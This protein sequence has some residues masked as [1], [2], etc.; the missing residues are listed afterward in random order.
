M[1]TEVR[2]RRGTTAQHVG[3][4]GAQAELTID[5][6]KKTAVVHDGVTPGGFP[7]AVATELVGKANSGANSD[8][9]SL[10]G[11]TTP[12]SI[13]QG[14]TGSV[15]AATARTALGAAASGTLASSGITGAAASGT[16]SDITSLT[17]LTT[18]ISLVPTATS[19]RNWRADS[20]GV[21]NYNV[22]C[23]ADEVVLR[24]STGNYVVQASVSKTINANGVVGAPLSIMSARAASTWYYIWLWYN[25]SL[26]LTATL[27]IS[28]TVPTAPTG[29]VAGDYK[30]LMPGARRTDAS[31]NTY[32]LGMITRGRRTRYVVL[33]G[34]NV[35]G[36]LTMASGT[37]GST[38]TPTWVAIATGT[39]VPVTAISIHGSMQNSGGPSGLIMVAPN[40]SYG[41]INSN[42][43][44]PY[45]FVNSAT[46]FG[47]RNFE[48][49][50]ES[51]NIYWAA[52]SGSFIYCQGWE[53]NL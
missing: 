53:E 39:F 27:D 7:L 16:N 11:L 9:T 51:T 5:T 23:S 20:T 36:T 35:T 4:T 1:A 42:T 31:G 43:N 26:G 15:S 47:Q 33:T 18:P 25:A 21:S 8:I 44:S 48:L 19:F 40:N 2:L 32:L 24:N 29:Y 41:A 28:S 52:N 38:A 3:F 45:A 13:P 37:A 30:A 14:G 50:L 6:T 17:G 10:S 22:I 34:S 49:L 46:D 12:L